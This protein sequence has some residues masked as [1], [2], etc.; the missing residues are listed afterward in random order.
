MALFYLVDVRM[1][2]GRDVRACMFLYWK[3]QMV[4]VQLLLVLYSVYNVG[5][6]VS[7]PS[8]ALHSSHLSL[9]TSTAPVGG[10]DRRGIL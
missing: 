1:V 5:I 3:R 10:S 7:F 8:H 4:R 9:G 2:V 6:P